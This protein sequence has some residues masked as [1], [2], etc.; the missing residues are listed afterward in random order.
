MINVSS[1][2][3][4][5]LRALQGRAPLAD[6]VGRARQALLSLPVAPPLLLKIAPDLTDEDK[7][8]IA[9]V[10]LAGGLDGLIVSNTT[11]ARPASLRSGA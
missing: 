10:A 8:D 2:N 3:T 5:G 1:P 4:P 7:Q 9:E 11:I 6:L